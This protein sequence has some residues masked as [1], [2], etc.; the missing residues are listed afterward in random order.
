M[1]TTDLALRLEERPT[2][3]A[4]LSGTL[5]NEPEWSTLAGQ[6]SAMKVL[7]AMANWILFSRLQPLSGSV[8]FLR[9]IDMRLNFWTSLGRIPSQKGRSPV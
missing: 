5:L 8:I 9:K 1:L 3:L 7:Q 2:H 4:V 6:G